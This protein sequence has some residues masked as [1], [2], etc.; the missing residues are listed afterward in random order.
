[1]NVPGL[2]STLFPDACLPL[3]AAEILAKL[4][5]GPSALYI[6]RKWRFCPDLAELDV[7]NDVADFF[8]HFGFLVENIC[9]DAGRPLPKGRR[10]TAQFVH[11]G[12]ENAPNVRKPDFF[13]GAEG[14]LDWSNASNHGELKSSDS[15]ECKD[16]ALKQL[17]NG[18]YHIFSSQDNRR[19]VVS[20][21][22]FAEQ[23]Q[24]YIFDRAGLVNT[25][26]FHIH[27]DPEAFVRVWTA[28]MFADPAVLG[29]DPTIV[30]TA[31]GV[32]HI[33]V[34]GRKYDIV[35]NA[36][37]ISDVIRGRGTVCWRV[38][39]EGKDFVIKDTWADDSRPNTE[40]EIL[41]IARSLGVVGIPQ[42]VA[43]EI[44]DVGGIRGTDALRSSLPPKL[45]KEEC[46]HIEKRLHRRLVLTPFG[47]SLYTFSTRKELLSALRDAIKAHQS[48]YDKAKI[49]H[50]DISV[51]NILL[52]PSSVNMSSPRP[53]TPSLDV[54]DASSSHTARPNLQRGLLIDVD[55]A[56]VL[57]P[58]GERNTA[59]AHRT[60]TLPF[61]AVEVLLKG[62]KLPQHLPRHDLESFLYVLIWICAHYAGPK[63]VVRQDFKIYHS[64]LK[65]WVNGTSYENV[66]KSKGWSM[67]DDDAWED[68][69]SSF[70]PYFEPLKTCATAWRKLFCDKQLNYEEV[71]QMLQTAIDSLDDSETWSSK[72]DP[73]GYGAWSLNKRKRPAEAKVALDSI[74]EAE[75]D[76]DV[77]N[78]SAPP[79]KFFRSGDV[80][81]RVPVRLAHSAPELK[82]KSIKN[83][84]KP[85][86]MS[87]KG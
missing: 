78:D 16:K 28:L 76:D 46:A 69:L 80:S 3:P 6:D 85:K 26:P 54:V 33:E 17:L 40:A 34:E 63:G 5:S 60:G 62:E 10:W 45:Y 70:A 25:A 79:L 51:Y 21:A 71:L 84:M 58:T 18:A 73:A 75:E 13:L 1:M 53:T 67:V 82:T 52:V 61:M 37:F 12:V 68:V 7:E 8:N 11:H 50:R 64:S 48:L 74:A 20:V 31:P 86:R 32:R 47:R 43:S 59:T 36:L 49:L 72:D 65:D 15:R 35:G 44:V 42:V 2:L 38:R 23:V 83:G 77:F 27:N 39:H 30:E 24:L 9:A 66:G 14:P 56:L 41:D 87:S 19:F 55:Y 29:Y 4:S 22:L 81:E 57:S